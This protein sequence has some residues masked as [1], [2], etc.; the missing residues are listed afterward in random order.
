MTYDGPLEGPAIGRPHPMA[1]LYEKDLVIWAEEQ[2]KA[3]LELRTDDV[4]FENVAE[5]IRCFGIKQIHELSEHTRSL[6]TTLLKWKYCRNARE[7]YEHLTCT[8]YV[9]IGD[10]RIGIE[11]PLDC[12]PSLQSR[13][14]EILADVYPHAVWRASME[15]GRK[16]SHFPET[17][18]WTLEEMMDFPLDPLVMDDAVLGYA[19]VISRELDTWEAYS[20]DFSSI[21]FGKT[22]EECKANYAEILATEIKRLRAERKPVPE[23]SNAVEASTLTNEKGEYDWTQAIRRN[24]SK[25]QE[26]HAELR[27]RRAEREKRAL[28]TKGP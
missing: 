1:D 11:V 17:L 25:D 16:E 23:P 28:E 22:P 27:A 15:T 20:P 10:D 5:E 9:Q 2:E 24:G 6:I 14:P 8:W 3:L 19:L 18:E 21:A 12:S 7:K 26:V 13:V 4:D